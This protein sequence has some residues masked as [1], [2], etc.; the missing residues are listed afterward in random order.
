MHRD[1]KS[2]NNVNEY[3]KKKINFQT[4][5]KIVDQNI[6]D[7]KYFYYHNIFLDQRGD[8]K[9]TWATIYETLNR[10]K[11]RTAFPS[12]FMINNLSVED[13]QEIANHF[14]RFFIHVGSDLSNK[15]VVDNASSKFTDYLTHPTN[16]NFDF[17]LTTENEILTIIN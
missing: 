1:W 7:A 5:E 4:L 9:K 6:I 8:M 3:S 11:N 10:S 16:L 12:N 15:I 14:D 17:N 2:T 13:L